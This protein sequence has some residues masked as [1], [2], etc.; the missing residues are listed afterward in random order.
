MLLACSFLVTLGSFMALPFLPIVLN[1]NVDMAMSAVGLVLAAMTA[2]QFGGGVFA[3]LA[4]HWLGTGRTML[5]ALSVRTVGFALLAGSSSRSSLVVPAAL[6]IAAGAALYLPAN[7]AYLVERTAPE[8]HALVLSVS[9]SMLNLGMAAGPLIGGI[10]LLG[11]ATWLF[12]GVSLLFGLITL[13]HAL[14]LSGATHRP[15]LRSDEV[16]AI[17]NWRPFGMLM[18]LNASGFY[19]YFFFQ[20]YLG[21]YT[22]AFHSPFVYSLA[23]ALNAGLLIV[24]QPLLARRIARTALRPVALACSV[25]LLAGVITLSGASVPSILL[26][27]ALV[28]LAEI[29]LFFRLELQFL[30]QLAQRPATAFGLQRLSCGMGASLSGVAGGSLF[31][32]AQQRGRVQEFWLIVGAQGLLLILLLGS[33][34]LVSGRRREHPSDLQP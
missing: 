25:L 4:A 20:N 12:T 19:I 30:K 28:T 23:L 21:P 2:I 14:G 24:G 1:R 34:W 9:T 26:G 18:L 15:R 22:V 8:N 32:Y 31:E 10:A 5:L 3:S 11:Y 6:L 29:G 27:T 33:W 16:S 7:K 13:L 17:D